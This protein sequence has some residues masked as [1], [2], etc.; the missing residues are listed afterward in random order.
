[1]R[2]RQ[3][4]SH[5]N[6]LEDAKVILQGEVMEVR[7]SKSRSPASARTSKASLQCLRNGKSSVASPSIALAVQLL[8]CDDNDG[9]PKRFAIARTRGDARRDDIRLSKEDRNGREK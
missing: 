9:K 4:S 3:N 1:M 2:R 6:A 8:S 5:V 7:N